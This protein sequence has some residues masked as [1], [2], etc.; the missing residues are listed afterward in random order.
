LVRRHGCTLQVGGPG[1][2]EKRRKRRRKEKEER[3]SLGVG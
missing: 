1:I 3:T 2:G